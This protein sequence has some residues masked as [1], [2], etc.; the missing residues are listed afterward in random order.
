M[1]YVLLIKDQ[2]KV[3]L[4]SLLKL[5]AGK[6]DVVEESFPPDVEFQLNDNVA[7]E[8]VKE[9]L[10]SSPNFKLSEYGFQMKFIQSEKTIEIHGFCLKNFGDPD[11]PSGTQWGKI[12]IKLA[13]LQKPTEKLSKGL[14]KRNVR[15][16][17]SKEY[18]RRVEDRGGEK[19]L[20]SFVT[21]GNGFLVSHWHQ[22]EDVER[23][24]K[25]RISRQKQ[26]KIANGSESDNK[27]G[28]L[29]CG[30]K[31]ADVVVY[32]D[33]EWK[34]K[35]NEEIIDPKEGQALPLTDVS[36]NDGA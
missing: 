7:V 5:I 9:K 6:H 15:M 34:H 25:T 2:L 13:T 36:G 19:C 30:D 17:L 10:D 28:Q 22:H 33:Y 29:Y 20:Y 26:I 31:D 8:V 35:K 23:I 14:E 3:F 24:I 18:I 32:E 4:D 1:T 21:K 16:G 11:N 12:Q 27:G